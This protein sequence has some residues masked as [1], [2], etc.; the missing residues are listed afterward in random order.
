MKHFLFTTILALGCMGA[1]AQIIG[2]DV[3]NIDNGLTPISK[4]LCNGNIMFYAREDVRQSGDDDDN[5]IRIISFYNDQFE[6]SSSI[7][8]GGSSI[9][10]YKIIKEM[11]WEEI[12]DEEGNF[13]GGRQVWTERKEEGFGMNYTNYQTIHFYDFDNNTSSYEADFTQTVFNNDESFEYI[14]DV[15]EIVPSTPI[16]QDRDRD[17]EIDYIET[18]YEPKTIGFEIVSEDGRVLQTIKFESGYYMSRYSYYDIYKIHDKYFLEVPVGDNNQ[19][20]ATLLYSINADPSTP[21]SIRQVGQLIKTTSVRQNNELVTIEVDPSNANRKLTVSST[22][23]MTVW[24]QD[25]PAGTTSVQVNASQLAKGVNIVA[26][27]GDKNENCKFI[28][29]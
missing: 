1:Q 12:Y 29:R 7:S 15:Y 4:A 17:G 28:I 18:S 24:Q 8:F 19:T 2:E 3:R 9:R 16:E 23:G 11:K 10:S 5:Y 13:V 27:S 26:V 6:K 14:R 25:I 20:Y 21:N 22:S